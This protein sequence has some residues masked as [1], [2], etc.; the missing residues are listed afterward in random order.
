LRVIEKKLYVDL[1]NAGYDVDFVGSQSNGIGFDTDHEGYG[2]KEA[3]ELARAS[4]TRGP[5]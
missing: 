1:T 4:I 2:G 3:W 5:T